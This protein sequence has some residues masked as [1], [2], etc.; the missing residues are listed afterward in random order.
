MPN[1][2]SIQKLT[3]PFLNEAL[4]KVEDEPTDLIIAN[5]LHRA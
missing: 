3:E 1:W 5:I 2:Q 4:N